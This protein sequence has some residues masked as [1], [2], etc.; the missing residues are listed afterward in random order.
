MAAAEE[1]PVDGG[2]RTIEAGGEGGE[3]EGWGGAGDREGGDGGGEGQKN[4]VRPEI[5]VDC[6]FKTCF[7]WLRHHAYVCVFLVSIDRTNR[8]TNEQTSSPGY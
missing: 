6:I 1:E 2:L 5:R 4:E 7:H 3:G 8:L